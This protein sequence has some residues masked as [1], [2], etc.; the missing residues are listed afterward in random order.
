[1]CVYSG[2]RQVYALL[3]QLRGQKVLRS[4]PP[5]RIWNYRQLC[6]AC[7]GTR[8][9]AQICQECSVLSPAPSGNFQEV[10]AEV[11][12]LFTKASAIGHSL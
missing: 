4:P 9:R 3:M 2:K 11:A 10:S 5:P 6:A 1:M 12:N 7:A 8:D